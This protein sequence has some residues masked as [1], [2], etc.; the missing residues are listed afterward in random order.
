ML[1]S[2][3]GTLVKI[4]KTA[5]T[6][7][8]REAV[9]SRQ[10][11]QAVGQLVSLIVVQYGNIG[12]VPLALLANNVYQSLSSGCKVETGDKDVDS[13]DEN[14]VLFVRDCLLIMPEIF[15]RC[16]SQQV[17]HFNLMH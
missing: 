10:P 15:H 12:S 14:S 6:D 13:S 4:S 5:T 9:D 3:P 16:L 2:K 7:K 11:C 1:E 17:F 8:F